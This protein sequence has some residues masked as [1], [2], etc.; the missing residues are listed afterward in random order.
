M[1]LTHKKKFKNQIVNN[2][3]FSKLKKKKRDLKYIGGV[4][5]NTN[6]NTNIQPNAKRQRFYEDL[7]R[8][9]STKSNVSEGNTLPNI[10]NAEFNQVLSNDNT[11]THGMG[12]SG[13]MNVVN[14]GMVAENAASEQTVSQMNVTNNNIGE[15]TP[16]N[17][18]FI[19]S[20]L[21]YNPFYAKKSTSI[22]ENNKIY[23]LDTNYIMSEIKKKQ[24]VDPNFIVTSA[25]ITSILATKQKTSEP[26]LVDYI[27][28]QEIHN[29]FCDFD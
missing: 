27:E 25:I 26:I 18:R 22:V 8:N 15:F 9:M 29:D 3:I 20:E 21:K 14:S 4:Y 6:T 11:M 10:T 28:Q 23:N 24:S 17:T 1:A 5:P 16:T 7:Q 2:D 12:A 19:Q 13:E